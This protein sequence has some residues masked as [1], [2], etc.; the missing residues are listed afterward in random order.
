M[1]VCDS[2][3]SEIQRIEALTVLGETT[4]LTSAVS[5]ASTEASYFVCTSFFR[6][7]CVADRQSPDGPETTAR[8]GSTFML[9][10]MRQL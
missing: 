5:S 9:T 8:T 3:I 6:K 7:H 10:H 1:D 4:P 2:G